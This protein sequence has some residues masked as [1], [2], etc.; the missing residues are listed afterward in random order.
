MINKLLSDVSTIYIAYGATD[1]R[2]Q[3]ASLCAEVR[4]RFNLTR[5]K[6][7]HSFFAIGSEIV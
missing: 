5:I 2:K 3:I 6:M 7:L 1:F 4:A